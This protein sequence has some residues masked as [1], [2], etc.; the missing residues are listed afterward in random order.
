MP[1]KPQTACVSPGCSATTAKGQYCDAHRKANWTARNARPEIRED[2]RFYDSREWKLTRERLLRSEPWCRE[3]RRQGRVTPAEMVDH[4]TPIRN[5]GSRTWLSNLQPLCH[6]CHNVK[7]SSESRSPGISHL[8][9]AESNQVLTERSIRSTTY[10][11]LM[12]SMT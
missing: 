11:P 4:I 3:C 1:M 5:G 7:R 9:N 2:K 8:G 6:T 12:N 10:K